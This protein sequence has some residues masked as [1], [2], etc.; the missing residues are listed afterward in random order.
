[1]QTTLSFEERSHLGMFSTSV[2]SWLSG[3]LLM[4]DG[5]GLCAASE[6]PSCSSSCSLCR[7]TQLDTY[8]AV[9]WQSTNFLLCFLLLCFSPSV[10]S[11]HPWCNLATIYCSKAFGF[12]VGS[13]LKILTN[14][15][16]KYVMGTL[17][18]SPR[19][20]G[21]AFYFEFI[22]SGYPNLQQQKTYSTTEVMTSCHPPMTLVPCSTASLN[23]SSL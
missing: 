17:R 8:Y 10:H 23:R 14:P 12:E 9:S 16:L 3:S 6:P 19:F 1:M 20:L 2:L 13:S 21:P 22:T 5:G 18:W 11:L 7:G 15:F 4:W